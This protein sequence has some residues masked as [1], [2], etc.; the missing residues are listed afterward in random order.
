MCPAFGGGL[1]GFECLESPACR[2][3]AGSGGGFV[4]HGGVGDQ[5]CSVA[6]AG[7]CGWA[8]RDRG[9]RWL[10]LAFGRRALAQIAEA[11]FAVH[12]RL[13]L[14]VVRHER[15]FRAAID[16]DGRGIHDLKNGEDVAPKAAE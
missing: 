12:G 1:I 9:G 6:S 8:K 13:G 15:F 16:G 3:S 11:V 14:P 10:K 7:D 4:E 5:I 2:R